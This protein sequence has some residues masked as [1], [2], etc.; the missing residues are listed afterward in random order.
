LFFL[1]RQ[2]WPTTT[3][4]EPDLAQAGVPVSDIRVA[5]VRMSS[6]AGGAIQWN[7]W[8]EPAQ[9]PRRRLSSSFQRNNMRNDAPNFPES[10]IK[11]FEILV[12]SSEE[13]S[14]ILCASHTGYGKITCT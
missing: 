6:L 2:G 11:N 5:A 8:P 7:K 14:K 12:K 4:A 1:F 9:Q 13:L 3:P 10:H